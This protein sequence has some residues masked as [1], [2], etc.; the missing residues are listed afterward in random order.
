MLR[1]MKSKYCDIFYC[2]GFTPWFQLKQL[3]D[4]FCGPHLLVPD[5]RGA[6]LD[7]TIVPV[8]YWFNF[9]VQAK[10]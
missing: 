7:V 1:D 6:A 8:D 4:V 5:S 2:C 3:P 9:T 10:F